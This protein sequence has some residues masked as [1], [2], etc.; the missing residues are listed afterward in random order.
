MLVGLYMTWLRPGRVLEA[1]I[2]G[3]LLILAAVAGGRWVE[4]HEWRRLFVMDAAH[5]SLWIIGYGFL[6]SVLPIWLLLAPR[7][8]SAFIKLGTIANARPRYHGAHAD[9]V[10]NG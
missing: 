8:T 7:D 9:P 1:S 3:V 2:I 10:R 4:F 6:A 5:L